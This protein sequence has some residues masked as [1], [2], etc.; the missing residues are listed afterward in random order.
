MRMNARI[1][2]YFSRFVPLLTPPFEG[3]WLVVLLYFGWC[4]LVYPGG[5]VLRGDLPDPDDYM[6]LVQVLDWLHGQG[7]YDNVQHRL[8][9]PAGVPIHFS[10]LTQIPMAAMI[11]MLRVLGMGDRGAATLMALVYPLILLGVFFFALR[12]LAK[13]YM[14]REWAGVTAFV[15][16]FAVGMMAK[17]QPGQVDHH[18]VVVILLTLTLGAAVRMTECPGKMAMPILAGTLLALGLTIALEILPWVLLVSVWLGVWAAVNG[19]SAARAG[20]VYA[21]TLWLASVAGLVLTRAPQHFFSPDILNYSFVYVILTGG[22]AASFAIVFLA[23]MASMTLPWRC[24]CAGLA[25]SCAA[26]FFLYLFPT[27]INGPYGGIDPALAQIILGEITEA[28]PFKLPSSGWGSMLRVMF[29]ACLAFGASA[30]F[31]WQSRRRKEELWRWILMSGLLL[32]A[33]CL[34]LF[35]QR[36]FVVTM[37]MLTIVPLSVLLCR[38]WSA[39]GERLSGRRK[40][41]AEIGLLLLVGVFPSVL[42]PALVDARPFNSGVLL[43]PAYLRQD[44]YK[45]GTYKLERLLR[46]TAQFGDRPRLIMSGLGLGPE[47]LF[48]TRHSVLTAPYHT[49]VGG[50]LDA[51]RFFS[52]PWPEEAEEIARRRRPDLVVACRY[53][54][55]IYLRTPGESGKSSAPIVKDFA[56]HFIERLMSGQV[57]AWLQR[58][59]APWL[60]N[61]VV[62]EVRLP[63]QNGSALP[64]ENNQTRG[65]SLLRKKDKMF[66]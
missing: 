24:A 60:D 28:F 20:F 29:G 27:L 38:G 30:Y 1:S 45:C 15:A 12:W 36:R 7:W 65:T 14:P 39:I 37:G 46:D 22:I 56:P 13:A 47:L 16:L 43:F 35:Y 6:Y 61:Y 44:M 66:K 8:D 53:I 58:V 3:L 57:P 2:R 26:L 52:T 21:L 40:T 49:D 59:Q 10:R 42:Y 55:M 17:F 50:N 18:G 19:A 62:Y 48:R 23:S 51:T 54:P 5:A 9:P 64:Q 63:D 31:A 34:A 25:A 11:L 4:F 41:Y 32:A 33:M